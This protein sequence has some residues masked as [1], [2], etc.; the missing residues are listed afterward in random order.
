MEELKTTQRF[1]FFLRY[2]PGSLQAVDIYIVERN[3]SSLQFSEVCIPRPLRF[4]FLSVCTLYS[5]SCWE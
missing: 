3:I 2:S 5:G 4:S 1:V